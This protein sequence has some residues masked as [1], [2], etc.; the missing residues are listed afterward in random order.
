MSHFTK[1]SNWSYLVEETKLRL[2]FTRPTNGGENTFALHENVEAVRSHTAG[3][4]KSVAILSPILD[5]ITIAFMILHGLRI[6]RTKE[7]SLGLD[8]HTFLREYPLVS[9]L[10]IIF[11]LQG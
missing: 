4:T 3:V 1:E 9:L 11:S 5:A 7:L 2:H 6:S 8:T 10:P